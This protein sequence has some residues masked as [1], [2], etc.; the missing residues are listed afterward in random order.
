VR[1]LVDLNLS[2]RLATGLRDAGHDVVHAAE[3]DLFAAPDAVL[4][5]TAR[6]SD[7]VV[8]TAD[9]DFGTL[10]ARTRAT[11]PSVL[12]LRR[13]QGRR[14]DEL[15][16]LIQANLPMVKD[17]LAE[18]SVVVLGEGTARIRRLPTV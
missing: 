2:P 14:V 6:E 11:T 12:Y 13:V 9:A 5:E 4:L 1:F 16:A 17:A 18:G 10:L 8:L 3:V 7:R 15:L